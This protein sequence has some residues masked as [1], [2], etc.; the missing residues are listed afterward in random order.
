M[1]RSLRRVRRS[2]ERWRLSLEHGRLSALGLVALF[3]LG[4]VA[5]VGC[6]WVG[7]EHSVRF[8]GLHN[9]RQ[10]SR[11][12][13]LPF[14][15]R[16]KT[17]PDDHQAEDYET[18]SSEP[19]EEA[20]P[21][22]TRAGEAEQRGDF[23]QARKLWGEYLELTDNG[24]CSEPY[25]TP[26]SCQQRRNSARDRL[27]AAGALD[28][29]TPAQSLRAYLDAR[30]AFDSLPIADH[31][32]SADDSAHAVDSS[33]STSGAATEATDAVDSTSNA[34]S[35]VSQRNATVQPSMESKIAAAVESKT[36]ADKST[37]PPAVGSKIAAADESKIAAADESKA[38]AADKVL[39]LLER[40]PRD[41]NIDDNVAY[42]RAAVLFREDRTDDAARAF[43]QLAARYP[44][45]EKREAALFTVGVM[46][47]HGSGSFTGEHATAEEACP[48]YRD[49]A[50]RRSIASFGRVLREYPRGR[51]AGDARG[52]LAYLHLRVG[53][54]AEGLAEYYRMLADDADATA[55]AEAV[56][57]LSLVRGSATEEEMERVESMIE[58][59]PRV[60][61]AYAYHD[62]YNV[63][64]R[65]GLDIEVPEE[66][67]PYTF[68]KDDD[69]HPCWS[70]Y[71]DW[72]QKVRAKLEGAAEHKELARVAAF[73]TRLMRRWTSAEVSGAFALRVAQADLALGD[74]SAAREASARALSSGLRDNERASAL[75][76]KGVAEHRLNDFIASRRTFTSLVG[77]FPDGDLTEGA[78]RYI[79]MAAED[80][81][82]L[83]GALEQ[84]LA[85]DYTED[86]AYFV[87][88]LM[89]P[90]QLAA[91]V[92]RHA[93]SP[94]RDMLLYSLGLRYMRAHR[95]DE[96]RAAYARVLT[97]D[98]SG[99]NDYSLSGECERDDPPSHCI[100]VKNPRWE[101]WKGVETAW[102]MRDLKTMDE[103]EHLEAR[104][105]SAS[106]DEA[107]AEALY[108]QA[109]YLYES[110]DLAFY[111]PAAWRGK[112]FYAIYYDQ[113]FRE[114]DEPRL[115]RR[116]MEEHEPLVRSL[117]IYLRVVEDYPRTRAARD[118]LYTAA[119]I[120]ERLSGF[121][122][123]WPEQYRQGLY[124][125]ERF[126]TYKD[127]RRVYPD[128]R[129][130][131]GT[132]GWE[133]STRTVNGHAAWPA[134][135]KPRQLTGMERARLK[136]KRVERRLSQGWEL[137]GEIGG[138]RVRSWT[139]VAL[140][141]LLVALVAACVLFVFRRTR[142]T[143][144]FLY[145]Q[146]TRRRKPGGGT[147]RRREVYA[148][149]SSYAAHVPYARG[150]GLCASAAR[151]AHGLLRLALH[152]RG[153]TAL[154]LNLFTHG[155]LT[156]LLW[157]VLWALRK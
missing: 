63:A 65:G 141:W 38:P 49:D 103:I 66:Q 62:I 126:V 20:D 75:W 33:D 149:G 152:E 51:Y 125:G 118:S 105:A 18:P 120:H 131:S 55:R 144:R 104:A 112:R 36:P 81:G 7:T 68:C 43:E 56:R 17:K 138:G 129:L 154:A 40:V 16:K 39:G 61:L 101:T 29:G 82:D 64:L 83:D 69:E 30:D 108:Q 19:A 73:A 35:V 1:R 85:L 45:S 42:L 107:K 135:P 2:V 53:E 15:A 10:F 25:G 111:N 150:A 57:S 109:S 5:A 14:D 4:A 13:P 119:V 146:L 157:A 147:A 124:A 128:Y 37:P 78:R 46:R 28:R 74:N 139:L 67:N 92:E 145:R 27:E 22:W 134:P 137:F 113:E 142:R 90:E 9:E 123:Y 50:W 133:P 84:Y 32:K 136:I 117:D 24:W 21:L 71:D 106:G 153:R 3:A 70:D 48:D 23:A 91:F 115:M 151:T 114:P 11:L 127:V 97:A 95:F 31:D 100:D 60:A 130:P 52:W 59:E 93:D 72:E 155:L 143:R 99:S 116:Y 94:A 88:V 96:A 41:G 98:E 34:A 121:E 77:E 110:S 79:A 86:A 132:R 122:L 89:T 6:G 47:L 8:N 102:V 140:R 87:D 76:V 54:T 156:V 58:N 44:R 26:T 80:A 148:P 12:P